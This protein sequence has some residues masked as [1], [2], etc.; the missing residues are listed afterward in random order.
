M[1]NSL[2]LHGWHFPELARCLLRSSSQTSS[3]QF[4]QVDRVGE[5]QM[6]QVVEVIESIL[7]ITRVARSLTSAEWVDE[8][9]AG[10]YMG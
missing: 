7:S 1:G 5:E 2:T 9:I 4:G 3:S 10:Y 8:H 6:M